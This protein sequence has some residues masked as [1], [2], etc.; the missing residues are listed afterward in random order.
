MG[1][2]IPILANFCMANRIKNLWGN[3]VAFNDELS[4]KNSKIHTLNI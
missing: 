4:S 2:T 3:F 1:P